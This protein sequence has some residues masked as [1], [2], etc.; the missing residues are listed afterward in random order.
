MAVDQN[1][2]SGRVLY[3]ISQVNA[4]TGVSTPTIRKWET[5]F[6]DYLQVV[7]TKGGQRRFNQD[8]VDKI[9]TLK[10]LIYEEGLS[11]EG[12]RKRLERLNDN[13]DEFEGDV[14]PTIEKLSEM[15]TDL[16]LKKLFEQGVNPNDEMGGLDRRADG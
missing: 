6:R 8:A 3:S 14:D 11:L 16:L 4:L 15:V 9:E 7:R 13:G 12:A 1:P 10:Q 2:D 5:A